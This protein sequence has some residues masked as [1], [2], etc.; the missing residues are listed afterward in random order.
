MIGQWIGEVSGTNRGIAVLNIVGLVY[1]SKDRFAGRLM[2]KDFDNTNIDFYCAVQFT[3]K[4]NMMEKGRLYDFFIFD[5]QTAWLY[6]HDIFEK[7]Y[8][9]ST[10]PRDG[11]ISGKFIDE[12]RIEGIWSTN[13]TT[14]GK[15]WLKKGETEKSTPSDMVFNSWGDF[16]K[17][18]SENEKGD[19]TKIYRGQTDPTQRLRTSLHRHNRND[20]ISYIHLDMP[21]LEI[22]VN[23]VSDYTFDMRNSVRDQYALLNLA[24]HH[25]YPTPLLDWSESVY[26]AT[27]FAYDGIN[28]LQPKEGHVRVYM[29]D[30]QRWGKACPSVRS[31]ID[32]TP[33]IT[34]SQLPVINNNRAVP[35]QSIFT[36]SNIDDIE[37][38]VELFEKKKGVKYLW[39]CDLPA[40][41]R[42]PIMCEL[43][44]MG[45]TAAS[46]FPGV[47][48]VCR[49]LKERYF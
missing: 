11:K 7:K 20:L 42:T 21:K 8:P 31:I 41:E 45:I 18:V 1:G 43:R 48:G 40:T 34:I 37:G 32:P 30:M 27:F 39:R 36:F 2:F 24:Q 17:W 28:K 6:K 33:S 49:A 44:Q 10:I 19:G 15:F 35:Q 25:G 47:D 23:A 13:I 29:F 14:E 9:G 46:L 26:V 3:V 38:F 22:Q 5:E 12:A 4:N 16:K